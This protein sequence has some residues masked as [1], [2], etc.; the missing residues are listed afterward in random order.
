MLRFRL[1]LL[2]KDLYRSLRFMHS[3]FRRSSLRIAACFL[4]S[5]S[6]YT[7]SVQFCSSSDFP[8]VL[9]WYAGWSGGCPSARGLRGI[10]VTTCSAAAPGQGADNPGP[11]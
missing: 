10:S 5:L 1:E 6:A 8:S 3:N 7:L 11:A 4:L 9:T 2:G